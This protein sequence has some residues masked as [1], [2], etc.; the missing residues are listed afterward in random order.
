METPPPH[1]EDASDGPP[2]VPRACRCKSLD[3]PSADERVLILT[4]RPRDAETLCNLLMTAGIG[5]YVAADL[6]DLV[7]AIDAGAAAGIITEGVITSADHAPLCDWLRQQPSWS[8]FPFVVLAARQMGRG[9]AL[10]ERVAGLGNVVLLER[11]L[12]GESLI[13]AVTSASRARRR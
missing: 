11:P 7:S 10:A 9:N 5:C 8:D 13:S 1:A 6:A 4:S 2:S 3:P 12:N